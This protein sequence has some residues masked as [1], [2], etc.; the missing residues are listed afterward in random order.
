MMVK[1]KFH[2]KT[3]QITWEY[4]AKNLLILTRRDLV[5]PTRQNQV[6][7]CHNRKLSWKSISTTDHPNCSKR[8]LLVSS[9]LPL[10]ANI[11]FWSSW[12]RYL[13]DVWRSIPLNHN[14]LPLSISKS[15]DP[16]WKDFQLVYF[17]QFAYVRM[18][19]WF[20]DSLSLFLWIRNDSHREVLKTKLN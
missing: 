20:I 10:S 13:R 16:C 7:M 1:G 8:P 19:C 14:P 17:S 12:Q 4:M 11:I 3:W 9:W 5:W 6:V 18:A 15:C 2:R